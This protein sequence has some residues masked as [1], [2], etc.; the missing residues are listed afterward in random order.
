MAAGVFDAD[1]EVAGALVEVEGADLES[2]LVAAPP[3]LCVEVAEGDEVVEELVEVAVEVDELVDILYGGG[4][5]G[6]GFVFV[7]EGGD[8]GVGGGT[9]VVAED[10]ADA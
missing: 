10:G 1:A 3:P 4:F 8:G 5:G 2:G 6:E 7:D 9:G